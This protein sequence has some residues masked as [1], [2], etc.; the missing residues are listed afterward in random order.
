MQRLLGSMNWGSVPLL[1]RSLCNAGIGIGMAAGLAGLALADPVISFVKIESADYDYA[2]TMEGFNSSRNKTVTDGAANLSPQDLGI[3]F[4]PN[5]AGSPRIAANLGHDHTTDTLTLKA[6]SSVDQG[7]FRTLIGM[8]ATLKVQA[9]FQVLGQGNELINVFEQDALTGVFVTTTDPALPGSAYADVIMRTAVQNRNY[10]QTSSAKDG[11]TTVQRQSS[12]AGAVAASSPEFNFAGPNSDTSNINYRSGKTL[13]TTVRSGS[14]FFVTGYLNVDAIT[15]DPQ[16][17]AS[18]NFFD[19]LNLS[20]SA[21]PVPE[22]ASA[23]LLVAGL[24]GLMG[25]AAVQ[26]R[27]QGCKGA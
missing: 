11:V 25:L 23:V 13:L 26:R 24:V 9:Q 27:P 8:H 1:G 18:S 15:N 3:T 12:Q 17:S 21:A 20:L 5:A 10:T 7:S 19:T 22:P 6:R 16:S 2:L 4:P 14:K